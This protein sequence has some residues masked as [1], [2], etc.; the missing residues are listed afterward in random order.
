[1]Q[2]VLCDKDLRDKAKSVLATLDH[3]VVVPPAP[4]IS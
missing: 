3:R 1:V 2:S 4:A